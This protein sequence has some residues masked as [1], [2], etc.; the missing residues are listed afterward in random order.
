M[1]AN[2]LDFSG[3]VSASRES[4]GVRLQINR[5]RAFRT[6]KIF[7]KASTLGKILLW[8]LSLD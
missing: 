7:P 2:A 5:R 3:I 4:R 6:A 8:K 1:R